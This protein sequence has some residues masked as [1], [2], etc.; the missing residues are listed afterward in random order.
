LHRVAQPLWKKPV[1]EITDL[2][3]NE[4]DS[5]CDGAP[6]ADDITILALR[7]DHATRR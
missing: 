6:Q 5:F 3:M 7:F 1:E 2:V 4:I